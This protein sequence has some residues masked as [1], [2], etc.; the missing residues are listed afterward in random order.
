MKW[1]CWCDDKVST[2]SI[3]RTPACDSH[4]DRQQT[5]GNSIFHASTAS[6]SKSRKFHTMSHCGSH[7]VVTYTTTAHHTKLHTRNRQRE[8]KAYSIWW[9]RLHYQVNKCQTQQ[10]HTL[11][12]CVRQ[13]TEQNLQFKYDNWYMR[14]TAFNRHFPGKTGLYFLTIYMPCQQWWT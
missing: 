12:T 7:V 4:T 11:F 1:H 5:Q 2:S 14:C 13:M 6:H 10:T 3:E 9:L 8:W